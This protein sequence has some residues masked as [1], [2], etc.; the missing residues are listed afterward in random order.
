MIIKACPTFVDYIAHEQKENLKDVPAKANFLSI[1][2]DGSTD[3]GNVEDELLLVLYFDPHSKDR[4]VHVRNQ[5][6]A[7]L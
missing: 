3:V 7:V 4:K 1:E 6:L 5:F 2:A